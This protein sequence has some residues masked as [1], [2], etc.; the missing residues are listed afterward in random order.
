MDP[1]ASGYPFTVLTG[2]GCTVSK[3]GDLYIAKP[4]GGKVAYLTV[5]GTFKLKNSASDPP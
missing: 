5:S 4:G 2:S 1:T 3:S